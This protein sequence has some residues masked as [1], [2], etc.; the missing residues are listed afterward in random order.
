MKTYFKTLNVHQ[1]IFVVVTGTVKIQDKIKLSILI[2]CK[3]IEVLLA[4]P[5]TVYFQWGLLKNNPYT[6]TVNEEK[7]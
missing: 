3:H 1:Y 5:T 4:Y 6:Y 7:W 2:N